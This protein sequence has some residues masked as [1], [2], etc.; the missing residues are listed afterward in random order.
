MYT[1]ARIY[2]GSNLQDLTEEKEMSDY[3]LVFDGY[4]LN[5]LSGATTVRSWDAVSGRPGFQNP[6]LTNVVD[7][8]PIP[9]GSW[10][11]SMSAVQTLTVVQEALGDFGRGAWPGGHIAW[12]INRVGRRAV[13]PRRGPPALGPPSCDSMSVRAAQLS[14]DHPLTCWQRAA[15]KNGPP[16]DGGL[17]QTA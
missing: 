16:K 10:N 8:G 2:L 1:N 6:S 15:T 13:M 17:G 5:L 3:R 12:G 11:F 4:R 9:E 7:K 14:I